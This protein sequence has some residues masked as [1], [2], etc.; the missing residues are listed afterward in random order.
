M[1]SR[2]LT[3]YWMFIFNVNLTE[4]SFV[5]DLVYL[6]SVLLLSFDFVYLKHDIDIGN[7]Y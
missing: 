2:D 7:K 1:P 3:I 6:F 5:L 4:L